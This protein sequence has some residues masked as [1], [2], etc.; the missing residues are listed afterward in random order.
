MAKKK[1]AQQPIWYAPADPT[2]RFQCPCCDYITLPER[3][4]YLICSVCFW[5]DDGQ[6]VDALDDPSGPNHGITLRQGRA[7]FNQFGA[8]EEAMV[9]NVVPGEERQ[10]FGHRPRNIG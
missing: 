10:R 4:N 5:E 2:P 1:R 8:C 9:K 7:N 6:D 3:G